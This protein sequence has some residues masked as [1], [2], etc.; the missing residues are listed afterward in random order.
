MYDLVHAGAGR[1][2][3]CRLSDYVVLLMAYGLRVRRLW[4][5]EGYGYG[6]EADYDYDYFHDNYDE[7]PLAEHFV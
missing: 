4:L 3:V 7:W 1:P 2:S 6:Y 5:N